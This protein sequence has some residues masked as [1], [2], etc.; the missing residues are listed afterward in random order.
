[1]HLTKGNCYHIYNRGNNKQ[2]IFFSENNYVFFLEK[3]RRYIYPISDILSWCLMPTHFHILLHANINTVSTISRN[4]IEIQQFSENIR[5]LLSSYTKAINKQNKFS[6]NLF[7]QKTK[8][9]EIDLAMN[10]N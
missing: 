9:K 3:V 4:G 7:Q 5:L 2:P 6:G 8:A 1:M 10:N